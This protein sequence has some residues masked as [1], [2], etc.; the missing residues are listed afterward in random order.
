MLAFDWSSGIDMSLLNF[1]CVNIKIYTQHVCLAG[2]TSGEKS[3]HD[4][5]D[6]ELR[7]LRQLEW[8][9]AVVRRLAALQH[10]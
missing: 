3:Q 8:S 5:D 4:V 6:G 2:V 7:R 9:D 1:V 10:H